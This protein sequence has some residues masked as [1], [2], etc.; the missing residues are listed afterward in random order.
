M[1]LPTSLSV[2]P[3]HSISF[4]IPPISP[5]C[6]SPSLFSSPPSPLLTLHGHNRDESSDKSQFE[7]CINCERQSNNRAVSIN[8]K[9]SRERI[10]DQTWLEPTSVCA[11]RTYRS[12]PFACVRKNTRV[13]AALC[14]GS[15]S[16]CFS[17]SPPFPLSDFVCKKKKSTCLFLCA[18]YL[19]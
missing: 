6:H 1:Y 12:I 15:T 10:G 5:L 4:L 7:C 13:V 3:G 19:G 14:Y 11:F 2:H 16:T 18:F 17:P 9:V 8:R